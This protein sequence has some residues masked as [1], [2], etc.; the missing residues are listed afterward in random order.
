MEL[1]KVS[2]AGYLFLAFFFFSCLRRSSRNGV[3]D[4]KVPVL[5]MP[6]LASQFCAGGDPQR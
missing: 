1:R 6:Q 2:A 5:H 4:Q 3:I